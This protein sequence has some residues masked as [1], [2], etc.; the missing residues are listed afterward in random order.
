MAI[1]KIISGGHSHG[2]L[3]GI[4]DYVM[5]DEKIPD[6]LI[7]MQ[8][9]FDEEEITPENVFDAFLEEKQTWNKDTGR[10]YYHVIVSFHE[11]EKIT[12]EEVLDF[13]IEYA[14]ACFHDFQTLVTVHQDKDHL[15][16]HFII[17]SVNFEDGHK[18]HS[19]KRD[20]E[21][22]KHETDRL[23]EERE[24]TITEKGLTFEHDLINDA[25]GRSWDL[26]LH[27]LFQCY[28]ISYLKECAHCCAQAMSYCVD[29][30]DFISD[31][32]KMGWDTNWTD[33]R[34]HITFV[35][36]YGNKFRDSNISKRF[37]MKVS[38]EE[39]TTLFER[40][41][42]IVEA[43][44]DLEKLLMDTGRRM[45]PIFT[46]EYQYKDLANDVIASGYL[47]KTDD[48]TKNLDVIK[49]HDQQKK[50]ELFNLIRYLG[51][52]GHDSSAE[53]DQRYMT[54]HQNV[55]DSNLEY[56]TTKYNDSHSLTHH[57]HELSL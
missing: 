27:E 10:M 21:E 4:I 9:P 16:L 20:L 30:E 40:R 23:C 45:S 26:Y 48:I 42:I 19:S 33:S 29:R 46:K 24:L 43:I 12:P 47:R 52:K 15:H 41:N 14:D 31:M 37:N 34:K 18:F 51:M 57:Q 25:T 44:K 39:L 35:N 22:M 28:D 7:F 11:D 32:K 2:A 1:T 50:Q 49:D 13:G 53:V 54:D 38:K 36:E 55:I 6:H 8:G 3:K 56:Y 5:K 17:N